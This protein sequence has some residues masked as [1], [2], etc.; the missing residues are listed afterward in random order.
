LRRIPCRQSTTQRV[1]EHLVAKAAEQS[2][3]N[4]IYTMLS[5]SAAYIATLSN[6]DDVISDFEGRT[7]PPLP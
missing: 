7:R 1:L 6:A 3:N 2:H 5:T 4:H